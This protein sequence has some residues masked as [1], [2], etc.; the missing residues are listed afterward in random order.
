MN[1]RGSQKNVMQENFGLIL[2]VK[3]VN[4]YQGILLRLSNLRRVIS[5]RLQR[6]ELIYLI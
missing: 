1:L 2:C 4:S 5:F 6:E 3:A